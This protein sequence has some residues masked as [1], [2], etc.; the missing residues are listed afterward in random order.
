[1]SWK[2]HFAWK[3]V[4]EDALRKG[5][6]LIVSVPFSDYGD[7]HPKLAAILD[8][9]DK[10]KIPVFIDAAYYCIARGVN[11]NLDRPCIENYCFLV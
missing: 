10:L 9:C 7:V 3:Y 8:Q 11:F 2:N 5:D 1:M 4:E 6:A